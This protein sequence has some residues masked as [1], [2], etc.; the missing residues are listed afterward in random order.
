MKFRL[1]SLQLAKEIEN[2]GE[3]TGH[4]PELFLRNFD[5]AVG[6]RVGRMLSSMFP[7]A[8]D[9]RGRAIVSMLHK[10]DFIFVRAH[11][12]IFKDMEEVAIQELG[13]RFTL[14]L[15]HVYKDTYQNS[16]PS[17][18]KHMELEWERKRE[19]NRREIAL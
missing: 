14:R 3:R 5:T 2:A 1:S 19:K 11:R 15:T 16:H 10:R 8:R 17:Q 7:I 18:G 13:P 6:K 4:V 12:Y 9:F